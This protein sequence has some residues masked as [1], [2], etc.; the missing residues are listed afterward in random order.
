[1]S[2]RDRRLAE[3]YA[4]KG[5]ESASARNARKATERNGGTPPPSRTEQMRDLIGRQ[6]DQASKDRARNSKRNVRDVGET[7]A[8][9]D[10]SA[11]SITGWFRGRG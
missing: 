2:A 1:M 7:F 10:R 8:D 9:N 3:K 4:A 6:R 11:R 5:K